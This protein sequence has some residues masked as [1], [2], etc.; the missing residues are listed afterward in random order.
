MTTDEHLYD[1]IQESAAYI[2]SRCSIAPRVAFVLG[3]G[4]GA[5]ADE[6]E[7][8][9]AIAYADIPHFPISTVSSHSGRLVIGTK[10]GVPVVVMAG[11][12]HY[13]EGYTSREVTFPIRVLH[14]L[15]TQE[16]ILTNAAGGINPHYGEGEIVAITDHINFIPDHPLRGY[17]DDRLG[18]RFPDMLQAYNKEMLDRMTTCARKIDLPLKHGVYLCLQ[19]PSLETPA[20]YRM[21]HILGADVLGMS[22]VP[23]VIVAHHAGIKV[24]AFSIVSNTCFPPSTLTVT[25]LEDVIAIVSRAATKLS[26]LLDLYLESKDR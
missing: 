15:G 8:A 2:K 4:L 18:L 21:A 7:D 23:E 9:I 11:R 6:V 16:I 14:A 20:E 3:T 12:F 17:N 10:K 24:A 13:Y 19:G 22:T 26:I 25:T 5:Y 1:R